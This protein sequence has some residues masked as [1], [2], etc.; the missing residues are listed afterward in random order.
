LFSGWAI[1]ENRSSNADMLIDNNVL[2][3]GYEGGEE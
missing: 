1:S 3:R 2:G